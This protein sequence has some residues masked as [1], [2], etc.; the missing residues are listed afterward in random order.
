MQSIHKFRLMD[1]GSGWIV[2]DCGGAGSPGR[3]FG[4]ASIYVSWEVWVPQGVMGGKRVRSFASANDAHLNDDKT[5][6]KMGHPATPIMTFEFR[7]GPTHVSEARH[8]APGFVV[9]RKPRG[10]CSSGHD[11]G[12]GPWLPGTHHHLAAVPEQF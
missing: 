6:A 5:V 8:G 12:Y 9:V 11:V 1:F 2:K 3:F 4:C 7:G 10:P